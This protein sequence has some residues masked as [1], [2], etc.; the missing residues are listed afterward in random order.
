MPTIP[1][2]DQLDKK[3]VP[4]RQDQPVYPYSL[5]SDGVSS[6]AEIEIIVDTTGRVLFPRIVSASN[7]DVGY[8]AAAAVSRWRYQPG[9]KGGKPVDSRLSVTITYDSA[10]MAASW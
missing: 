1:H 5:Q 7:E 10:K 8:A 6:R 3:P 9:Q 2:A 4:A